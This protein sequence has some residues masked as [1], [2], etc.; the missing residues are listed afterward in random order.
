MSTPHRLT[1]LVFTM[2]CCSHSSFGQENK[3]VQWLYQVDP[4][5][6]DEVVIKF[7]A[8]IAQGW[9]LY[10]QHLADGGPMPTRF[11]FDQHDDYILL[12]QPE[13]KGEAIKFHDDTYEMEI[14]WYT[15]VVSFVQRVRLT[16]Q[17]NCARGTIEFMTCND[18]TCIPSKHEFSID[19]RKKT[20]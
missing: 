14:T 20:P 6:K 5:G 8:H 4:S 2:L 11:S 1:V 7:T 16:P 3:T 19:L 13:E 12:S 15:Q 17:A 18:H 9:H 10:S